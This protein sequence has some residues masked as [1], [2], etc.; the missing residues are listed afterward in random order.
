MSRIDYLD[1]PDAPKANSLVPAA[2]AIIKNKRGRILLHRRADNN[3]WALPGGTMEIGESIRETLIREVKEETGLD[4]EPTYIV[5]VYTDPDHVMAFSDGEVRQEF[6]ICFACKVL[7][8]DLAISNESTKLAYFAAKKI[9]ALE[10]HES[11]RKRIN[12]YLGKSKRAA[13]N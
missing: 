13:I 11:I 5:G 7:G 12:D 2:S 4:V 3:L 1:D 10:M 6:S 8:G 9:Q